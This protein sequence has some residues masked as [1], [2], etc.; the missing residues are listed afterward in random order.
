MEG[1]YDGGGRVPATLRA[2][3]RVSKEER[4]THELTHTPYRSWCPHCVKGR[5]RGSPHVSRAEA[6][7][8]GGVPKIAMD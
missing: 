3:L 4:E 5:A 2:P 7:K 1:D 8:R 6:A